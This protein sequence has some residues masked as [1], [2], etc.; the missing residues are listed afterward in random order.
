MKAL[1][2]AAALFGQL[3]WDRID[4]MRRERYRR[5][6]ELEVESRRQAYDAQRSDDTN[7]T[8][9]AA[10]GFAAV[11]VLGCAGVIICNRKR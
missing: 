8:V 11:V 4:D 3:S 9:V 1:L 2:L 6:T 10:F 5:N 7:W